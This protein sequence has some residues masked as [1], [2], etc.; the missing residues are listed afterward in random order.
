M[1]W[2]LLPVKDVLEKLNSSELGLSENE[3]AISEL[4][5]IFW[6]F[7]PDILVK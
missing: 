3:A 2:R 4:L 7:Q 6:T 5:I 1:N